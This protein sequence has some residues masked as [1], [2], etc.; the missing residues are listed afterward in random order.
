MY[1]SLNYV[2]L[3]RERREAFVAA[4]PWNHGQPVTWELCGYQMKTST[5]TPDYPPTGNFLSPASDP[6]KAVYVGI[7]AYD[8]KRY[9]ILPL[10]MQ[11]LWNADK[12]AARDLPWLLSEIEGSLQIADYPPPFQYKLFR[13]LGIVYT[14]LA[15]LVTG[16][17]L[18]LAS[19]YPELGDHPNVVLAMCSILL[20]PAAGS[21]WRRWYLDIRRKKI[22]SQALALLAGRSG[23]TAGDR[24]ASA[25]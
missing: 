24:A 23:Y 6:M 2:P 10:A 1:I 11:D 16:F 13:T 4:D 25:G 20:V 15:L 5:V 14:G 17:V 18:A 19:Q 12:L 8:G 21:I 9:R 3:L 22:A 7:Q